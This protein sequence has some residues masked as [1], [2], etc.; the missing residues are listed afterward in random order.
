MTIRQALKEQYGVILKEK[1][2]IELVPDEYSDY[3]ISDIVV[4]DG[5]TGETFLFP[6]FN[7]RYGC[8]PEGPCDDICDMY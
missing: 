7:H 3:M 6:A 5:E 1:D 2:S 8:F 4:L